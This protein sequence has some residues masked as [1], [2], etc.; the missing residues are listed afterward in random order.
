MRYPPCR[1]SCL[2]TTSH[3]FFRLPCPWFSFLSRFVPLA[4][5]AACLSHQVMATRCRRL[6]A[7]GNAGGLLA[8]PSRSR[9]VGRLA[10]RPCLLDI[11]RRMPRRFAQS[12]LVL[13]C[14]S[15]PFAC[16][17]LIV[18][19]SFHPVIG[20]GSVPLLLASLPASSTRRTGRYD[21]VA[22]GLSALLACSLGSPSHPCGSAS[23]GD[24]ARCLPH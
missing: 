22:A 14:G 18:S 6:R 24:G 20:S 15:P 11:C 7:A 21:G 13:G 3:V 8:C 10:S 17:C 19:S 2:L 9:A 4:M 5:W 23:D 16:S 1:Q 12:P